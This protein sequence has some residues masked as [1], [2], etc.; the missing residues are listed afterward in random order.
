MPERIR[1]LIIDDDEAVR[2]TLRANLE[3]CGFQVNEAID[4]E[5]GFQLI[6]ERN[7]PH[8]VITDIIMPRREGL[9]TIAAIRKKFPDLKLIAISGGGRSKTMDF[10]ELAEKVGAHAV[11][12]K[13]LDLDVLEKT[14]RN[15]AG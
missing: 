4:G 14:V 1:V 15:L 3:D 8:V 7:P 10:L 12:P 2:E 5:Q 6:D 13:P 9:E 11:L